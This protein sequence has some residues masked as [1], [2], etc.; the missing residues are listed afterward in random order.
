MTDE[1]ATKQRSVSNY[2]RWWME[3]GVGGKWPC[4]GGAR[5]SRRW[6]REWGWSEQ[7]LPTP[8]PTRGQWG[9]TI[10]SIAISIA[11]T[12][13][14]AMTPFACRCHL[15]RYCILL[16]L[17]AA[18]WGQEFKSKGKF[19]TLY[20]IFWFVLEVFIII[21]FDSPSFA[22]VIS[23][24]ACWVVDYLMLTHSSI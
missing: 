16:G 13:S 1:V 18:H 19:W 5:F 11:T 23:S 2:T 8:S 22:L 20:L 14:I 21:L 10:V 6:S 15:Y 9:D 17:V 24:F 3:Q 4:Q 7:S 12:I